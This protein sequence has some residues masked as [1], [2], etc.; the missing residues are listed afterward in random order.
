MPGYECVRRMSVGEVRGKSFGKLMVAVVKS[1]LMY[2]AEVWGS[3]MLLTWLD[4]IEQLQ[5]RAYR[6]FL[7][8]GRLHPKTSLQ[9]EMGLLPLKWEAKMRCIQFWHKVMTMGEE[10]LV[11]RVAMESLSLQGEMKW[12]ENLE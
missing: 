12:Q 9:I 10:R 5:L 3:C 6:I 8:V 4:C 7:G 11:K 2:G 1:A